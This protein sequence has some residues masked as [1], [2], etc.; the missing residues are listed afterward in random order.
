VA[1][2]H[3]GP[4]SDVEIIRDKQEQFAIAKTVHSLENGKHEADMLTR[5]KHPGISPL[6]AVYLEEPIKLILPLYSIESEQPSS[7]EEITSYIYQLLK[8]LEHCAEREIVHSDVAPRN[9]IRQPDGSVILI[10]F[11]LAQIAGTKW[12]TKQDRVKDKYTNPEI[13]LSKGT[14]QPSMDIWSAG[15]IMK[16]LID[17]CKCGTADSDNLL[18]QML[19]PRPTSRISASKALRHPFFS[20]FQKPSRKRKADGE[21]SL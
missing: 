19:S 10:D 8:A 16:E 9:L 21:R 15:K 3:N 7:L 5:L 6:L 4:T 1:Q 13:L 12:N 17:S 20:S 18:Q 11:G 14:F 2:L